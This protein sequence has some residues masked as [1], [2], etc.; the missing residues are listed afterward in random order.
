[1]NNVLERR[2]QL[3]ATGYPVIPLYGKV[4]PNTKNNKNK[5]R[6]L[7]GW[8]RL[9]DVSDEMLVMWSKAW[10]DAVGTGILTKKMPTLDLDILN[11]EAVRSLEDHVREQYEEKGP[12]LVRIGLPPKRAIPFRTTE[13]FDKFVVN[14]I[15]PNGSEE[16]IEFLGDGAQVAAFGIHPD[17]RQPY[18]WHGGAP[19]DIKLEDLPYIGGEAA[20]QLVD[21]LVQMLV[22]RFGYTRA[23]ERPGKRKGKGNG[24]DVDETDRDAASQQR[25]IQLV[26]L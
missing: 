10:P 5:R 1:M 25:G 9:G 20:H 13:P 24:K 18:R 11:E 6:S 23:K 22:D 21:E 26:K 19:G 2:R 4:P 12:I 14:L 7:I 8:E 3:L 15:A 16:K 17:T